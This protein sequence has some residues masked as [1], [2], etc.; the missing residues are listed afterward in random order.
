MRRLTTAGSRA[1][2]GVA[3]MHTVSAR[4][5]QQP[6][7]VNRVSFGSHVIRSALSFG[8]HP[9][10]TSHTLHVSFPFERRLQERGGGAY[11]MAGLEHPRKALRGG[12]PAPFLEPLP[13]FVN[14]WRESPTFPE[15]SFK[16]DF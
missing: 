8:S 11:R 14:I 3:G 16:I 15:K 13:F 7:E 6:S 2:E 9:L 10:G 12:I 4:L 1:H 5:G